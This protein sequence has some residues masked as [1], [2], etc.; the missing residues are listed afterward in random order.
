MWMAWFLILWPVTMTGTK[1]PQSGRGV[2]WPKTLWWSTPGQFILYP[3]NISN[4]FGVVIYTCALWVF[5][6][7][8]KHLGSTKAM[9]Q[10]LHLCL[11]SPVCLLTWTVFCC[12]CTNFL[13]Q[14]G[15][16][17][18]FIPLC[19][20]MWFL[21]ATSNLKLFW[22]TLHWYFF[23]PVWTEIWFCK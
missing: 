5:K 16:W 17:K 14:W 18:F 9:G 19:M 15:H 3:F 8:L 2:R 11:L 7:F 22:Q 23:S 20:F 6:W 12:L 21:K 13:S 10:M 1:C 4:L